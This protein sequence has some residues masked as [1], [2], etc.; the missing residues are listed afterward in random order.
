MR[1]SRSRV[2]NNAVSKPASQEAQ[3]SFLCPEAVGT[4]HGVSG[5]PRHP[6]C[7]ACPSWSKCASPSTRRH[8]PGSPREP[9]STRFLTSLC[10][11]HLCAARLK[12]LTSTRVSIRSGKKCRPGRRQPLPVSYNILRASLPTQVPR[13]KHA[14]RKAC[15]TKAVY[16]PRPGLVIMPKEVFVSKGSTNFLKNLCRIHLLQCLVNEVLRL[17]G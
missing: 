9:G 10:G 3:D 2:R 7:K 5:Q 13:L 6:L 8:A 15:P 17:K 4:L 16:V 14:P 12:K 11:T 1:F